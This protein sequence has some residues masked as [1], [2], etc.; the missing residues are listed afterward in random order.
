MSNSKRETSGM[1]AS[2][3]QRLRNIIRSGHSGI[4]R[5]Y[6]TNFNALRLSE[7]KE[8]NYDTALHAARI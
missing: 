7:L 5:V 8:L 1:A 4:T 6:F 3:T 2:V